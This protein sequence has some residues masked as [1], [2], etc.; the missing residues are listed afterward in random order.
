MPPQTAT[1]AATAKGP[2]VFR[3]DPIA[4][5]YFLDEVELPGVSDILET[6][7]LKHGWRGHQEA[8]L[9]GQ[10][11]HRCCELLDQG[12]LDWD[13]VHP[14]FRGY[15]EAWQRFTDEYGVESSLIEY[16]SYHP[17]LRFGGTLDRRAVVGRWNATAILDLKTGVEEYWHR[18]QTAGYGTLGGAAWVRDCRAAVYV[19]EDGTY[20]VEKY[21]DTA[22]IRVFLAALTITHAKRSLADGR[23]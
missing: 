16:R 2:P 18:W 17:Q 21:H 6:A 20:A 11:V 5:R 19:H 1:L 12:D 14:E 23:H 9:R 15:V 22:D 7:G 10:H 4:H 13:S 8:Q 3:F